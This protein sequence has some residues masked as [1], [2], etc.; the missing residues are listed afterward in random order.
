MYV[1]MNP[2]TGPRATDRYSMAVALVREAL[3]VL[4]SLRG[5]GRQ[6]V[7]IEIEALRAAAVELDAAARGVDRVG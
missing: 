7:E 2:D 4:E 5:E 6:R 1:H 3:A